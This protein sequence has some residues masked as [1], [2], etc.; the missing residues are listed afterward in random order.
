MC[1]LIVN[2]LD[3][4]SFM[5]YDSISN[6]SSQNIG[7][8]IQKAITFYEKTLSVCNAILNASQCLV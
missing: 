4:P 5:K 2:F 7:R 1:N 8:L 3:T 6:I